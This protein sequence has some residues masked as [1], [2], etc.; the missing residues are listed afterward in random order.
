MAES[1]PPFQLP[2]LAA[3]QEAQKA[4]LAKGAP[5]A[6]GANAAASAYD[7]ARSLGYQ[8][9]VEK[10]LSD[11]NKILSEETISETDPN[12][13]QARFNTLTRTA[14][15]LNE[16]GYTDLVQQ[17]A[18]ELQSLQTRA[19]E[20]AKLVSEASE[21]AAQTRLANITAATKEATLPAELIKAAREADAAGVG[22]EAWYFPKD[23][24]WKTVNE[25]DPADI[26]AARSAGAFPVKATVQAAGLDS[27]FG[28]SKNQRG[29]EIG[30]F[31]IQAEAS[32]KLATALENGIRLIDSNPNAGTLPGEIATAANSIKQN[33]LAAFKANG[34]ERPDLTREGARVEEMVAGSLPRANAQQ[35]G[36]VTALVYA[37]ARAN[38]PGGRL[39]N[40]DVQMF[41]SQFGDMNPQQQ[42]DTMARLLL[43]GEQALNVAAGAYAIPEDDSALATAKAAF[44]KAK[45]SASPKRP[46]DLTQV[47][48]EDLLKMLRGDGGR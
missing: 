22:P 14:K 8:S 43:E 39:S 7:L 33:V 32:A 25:K 1:T 37:Q 2:S 29:E 40:Q 6:F 18:P 21:N 3:Y 4:Q 19:M 27:M 30:K 5:T 26:E 46:A 28:M 11:A 15:R 35:K 9:R 41:A 47:P 12:P 44:K 13:T 48:T 34:V 36:M 23:K 31:R 45:E 24:T 20:Q 17:I 42:R 38:D 16:L 10:Q